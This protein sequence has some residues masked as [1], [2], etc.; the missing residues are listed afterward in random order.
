MSGAHIFAAVSLLLRRWVELQMF[1]SLQC[2]LQSISPPL[3][4]HEAHSQLILFSFCGD[5]V[6]EEG[7]SSHVASLIL[8]SGLAEHLLRRIATDGGDGVARGYVRQLQV[9]RTQDVH[10]SASFGGN[11]Q[12]AQVLIVIVLSNTS[13]THNAEKGRRH[14]RGCLQR[15]SSRL[16]L[17]SA[18][19]LT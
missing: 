17:L 11:Q 18:F 15:G 10:A 13:G 14:E 3:Q 16:S 19:G 4:F 9:K 7:R 6:A 12:R 1:D 2:R 8:L 5:V